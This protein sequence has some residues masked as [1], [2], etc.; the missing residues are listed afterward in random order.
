MAHVELSLSEVFAPS[1]ET[2]P[3]PECDNI[4]R[5]SATV[6][7]AD[8]PC[9]LIDAETRVLA[10]STAACELLQLGA[11]EDVI[12]LPLLDGGLRL[13][14]F[15]AYRGELAEPEIDKIPPLLALTSGRL[16]RGLLRIEAATEDAADATVDAIST[17]V[18]ADGTVA[19]SL[20]FFSEV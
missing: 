2:P 18:V 15:T 9:L 3:E 20:T 13:L 14:D 4:G 7:S 10:V 1:G 8:E 17:P 11:P 16:A 19:G 12:G 6:S 5:W